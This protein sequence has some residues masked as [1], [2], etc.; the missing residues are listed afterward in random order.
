MLRRYT[1]TI[2]LLLSALIATLLFSVAVQAKVPSHQ[3]SSSGSSMIAISLDGCGTV[4]DSASTSGCCDPGGSC[5]EKQCCSHVQLSNIAL[6][7]TTVR[8]YSAPFRY[9][10]VA[11][12]PVNYSDAGVHSLYRPPIA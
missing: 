2:Y 12:I 9:A 3:V 1:P 4:M 5:F 7:E 6:V 11:S 8:S 10:L